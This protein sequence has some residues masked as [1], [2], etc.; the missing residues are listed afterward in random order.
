MVRSGWV[1][2]FV[3]V[4]VFLFAQERVTLKNGDVF[5]GKIVE[6][7][8]ECVVLKTKYGVLRIP[9]SDI[10]SIEKLETDE[11]AK[12]CKELAEA[13]FR[14]ALWCKERG[15]EKRAK[16]HLRIVIKLNP[17]HAEARKLLGFVRKGKRWVRE[18]PEEK[19]SPEKKPEKKKPEKKKPQ[20][21]ITREELMSA[22]R[23]ALEFL[24]ANKF[25]EAIE[26]YKAILASFPN[27]YIA[28]YNIACAYARLDKKDAAMKHLKKAVECGFNDM[29][30][31][32]TDPDLES[33]RDLEEFKRLV[34]EKVEP[35]EEE[36]PKEEPKKPK[37]KKKSRFF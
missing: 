22:H 21:K 30:K 23:K 10:K 35:K 17:D 36:E 15:M 31:I 33:L 27:D 25:E 5:E 8:D 29:E 7:S 24:F 14:L 11:Y 4:S 6:K 2:V 9:H 26:V 20:K 16:E 37:E 3:L 13:H 18:K 12:K 34:G 1:F 28:H 32:K 19:K